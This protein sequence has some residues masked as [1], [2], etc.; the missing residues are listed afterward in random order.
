M[1]VDELT[2]EVAP[3]DTLVDKLQEMYEA[4]NV[5]IESGDLKTSGKGN[6]HYGCPDRLMEFSPETKRLKIHSSWYLFNVAG[7][8]WQSG[9]MFCRKFGIMTQDEKVSD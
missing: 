4:A 7:G 8:V 6:N 3:N 1:G 2:I 5:L 9:T